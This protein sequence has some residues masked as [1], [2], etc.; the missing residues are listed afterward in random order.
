MAAQENANHERNKGKFLEKEKSF[1]ER[2]SRAFA[3][4]HK[5]LF[6]TCPL[7]GRGRPLRTWKGKSLFKVKPNYAIIQTRYMIGGKGHGGFYL[8]EDEST[9][10]EQLAKLF[11]DI[12]DNLKREAKLLY[13]MF[14]GEA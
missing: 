12:Y 6:L 3:A 4:G 7:C 13:K 8:K 14:Y 10:V 5:V 2:Q 1:Y 11:P 9:F